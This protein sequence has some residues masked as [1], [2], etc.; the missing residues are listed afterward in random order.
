MQRQLGN[1]QVITHNSTFGQLLT[2]HKIS[3]WLYNGRTT[4]YQQGNIPIS[5][6][7][8]LSCCIKGKPHSYCI[9]MYELCDTKGVYVYYLEVCTCAHLTDPEHNTAFS[10]VDR[11]CDKTCA[12]INGSSPKIFDHLWVCKTKAVGT[13]MSNRKEVPRQAFS[14]ELKK[15]EI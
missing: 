5:R 1:S 12:W 10:A 11:L 3:G 9:K 14:W 15:S 2:H 6:S 13:V 7:Y 8:I 4:D